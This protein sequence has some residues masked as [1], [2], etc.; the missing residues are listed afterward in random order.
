MSTSSPPVDMRDWIRILREAGELHEITAEVDPHLEI[1]EI[2]DRTTKE[3][4]PALL[5]SNV[6][7][8][9]MPVLINQFGS[10]RRLSLAFG[11]DDINEVGDRIA[12]MLELAPPQGIMDK[13]RM[14]GRLRSLASL[15][16]KRVKSAPVQEVVHTGDD[17]SLDE[18]PILTCWPGDGGPYI[19]L[20]L[21]ITR[22]SRTGARN[23]GMYRIQKFDAKTTGMHWQIHKDGAE[24]WRGLKPG[25]R[26]EV[27]VAIGSDPILTYAATAPLPKHL[28]ELLL[29]G[30]L[31]GR[32][33][34][35]VK[36]VTVDLE[37]PANAEI[38]LEG[39]IEHGEL[40]SEGP[41]GD[42]TGYY[43][44]A[45]DYPVFHVTAVTHR[46]NPVYSATIVGVPPQEDCWIGKAT[47]RIFL[48]L[49]RTTI[50]EIVD[51]DLPWAGVFHGCAIVSIEKRFPGHA[52]KV[53]QAIWGTGLLSLTKTVIVV[54][55]DVDVHDYAEVAFRTFGNLDPARDVMLSE[56]PLDV[57]DHAPNRMGFGGKLGID[58]TRTWPSEGFPRD[59]PPDI[60]M[61]ESIKQRVDDRWI[62]Y[63]LPTAGKRTKPYAGAD[64]DAPLA[65]A[66]LRAAPAGDGGNAGMS[67]D[68][69]DTAARS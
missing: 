51:Y 6:R 43:S 11:V 50:P 64:D 56:G 23:L 34:E 63:G 1:T 57:L 17:V 13:V 54:D 53:M 66:T 52:R 29:A 12:E 18:L 25:E 39:Y 14:L 49:V 58:A 33:V 47:E 42:H 27:A 5:F 59:W 19:T 10:D 21:V 4:G 36:G 38:I 22:D 24:D 48:P 61:T 31:S 3:G 26:M 41:F 55:A 16:P 32:S 40:R 2:T 9:S 30:F 68:G 46:K 60:A 7:G 37:V 45:D 65:V 69:V 20:P 35:L 8:S 62:E 67:R 28:D 44:L 15:P